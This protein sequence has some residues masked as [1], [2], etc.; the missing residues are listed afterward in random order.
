[1]KNSGDDDSNSTDNDNLN[2]KMSE[3]QGSIKD[4]TT[5]K[6]QLID[7]RQM[8]KLSQ[9]IRDREDVI[10]KRE[11]AIRKREEQNQKRQEATR[12]AEEATREAEEATREAEEATREAEE[13]TR[14]AE[15]ATRETEEA[16]RETEE[17]TRE[18]EEATREAEELKLTLGFIQKFDIFPI[19]DFCPAKGC[20]PC[21]HDWIFFQKKCYLF[22]DEP[23]PWKTWEQSRRFCQDRRADLVVIDDLEE[24]EFVSKHVKSYFDIQWGYWLGL[25]QTNNTWTWVDGHVDTLGC[26]NRLL[27]PDTAFETQLILILL[28]LP[29]LVCVGKVCR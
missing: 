4:L 27:G 15:E 26:A 7:E 16:T 21:L 28:I 5:E 29:L 22:Y 19:N 12:E 3:Q 24:Q 17:A 20:K 6:K 13:A 1:M 8:V 14:E 11:G 2:V 9:A 10:Q 25:Q 23:A 18:A